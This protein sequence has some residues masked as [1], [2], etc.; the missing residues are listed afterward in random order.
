MFLMPEVASVDLGSFLA[1]AAV[2]LIV[3]GAST[4][5][6]LLRAIHVDPGIALRYE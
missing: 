3:V 2:L 4:V 1:V 6:P 5:P